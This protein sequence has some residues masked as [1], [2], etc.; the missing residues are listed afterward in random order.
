MALGVKD[1]IG[2]IITYIGTKALG[3]VPLKPT[4]GVNIQGTPAMAVDL[5]A[6]LGG[7]QGLFP[8]L[9]AIAGEFLTGTF[10]NLALDLGLDPKNLFMSSPLGTLTTDIGNSLDN[11]VLDL[12]IGA[13]DALNSI[14]AYNAALA[15][16]QSAV[17]QMAGLP[18]TAYADYAKSVLN[19]DVPVLSPGA[20]LLSPINLANNIDG[21]IANAV[22]IDECTKVA[23]STFFLEAAKADIALIQS[24]VVSAVTDT[25]KD[26]LAK[27]LKATV[28]DYTGKM[29][30]QMAEF[31][32]KAA[33]ISK[34]L[35]PVQDMAAQVV[36]ASINVKTAAVLTSKA[37]ALASSA[38]SAI[39]SAAGVAANSVISPEQ[40]AAVNSIA[41]RM[42]AAVLP[43]F[44]E[45]VL[46]AIDKQLAMEANTSI[47]AATQLAAAS[48]SIN[49]KNGYPEGVNVRYDTVG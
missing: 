30:A 32:S 41:Q 15:S 38:G 27:E 21:T 48:S 46:P 11:L 29:T 33:E 4:I 34:N 17:E 5:F 25:A 20:Q 40:L 14:G 47:T 1:V 3:A 28:Q 7:A 22:A 26:L 39:R 9:S 35:N 8:N 6:V 19:F 37:T 24:R 43:V 23:T 42:N 2:L 13:G 49:Y 10:N 12:K 45:Q 18:S 16:Y 36:P 44:K 31:E